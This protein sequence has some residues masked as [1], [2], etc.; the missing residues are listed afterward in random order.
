MKSA[1]RLRRERRSGM[2]VVN[3][4]LFECG[5]NRGSVSVVVVVKIQIFCRISIRSLRRW[6]VEQSLGGGYRG[7]KSSCSSVCNDVASWMNVVISPR[8]KEKE[9]EEREEEGKQRPSPCG[10]LN[11]VAEDV[12]DGS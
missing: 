5:E 1:G 10:L 11:V 4:V 12:V 3:A 2:D 8:G 6:R 9:T 7:G